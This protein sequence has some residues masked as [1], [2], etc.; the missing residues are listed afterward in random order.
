MGTKI[1]RYSVNAES[2]L[3]ISYDV[4]LGDKHAALDRIQTLDAPTAR[5][6]LVNLY[7]NAPHAVAKALA[8]AYPWS[9]DVADQVERFIQQSLP[10]E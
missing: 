6:L 2:P 10:L 1:G 7:L 3:R 4:Y 9:A 5:L 8:I